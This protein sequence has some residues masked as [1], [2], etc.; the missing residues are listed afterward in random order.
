MKFLYF[1]KRN[2]DNHENLLIQSQNIENHDIHRIQ[3]QNNENHE[4]LIILIQN[5]ENHE[6]H[7]IH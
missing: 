5:H 7:R 4:N 3:Q 2:H 6:I 1:F